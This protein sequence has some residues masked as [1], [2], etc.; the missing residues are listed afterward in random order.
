[1]D[2]LFYGE[3]EKQFYFMPYAQS[4]DLDCKCNS[5][6]TF[7]MD[8][9]A[10]EIIAASPDELI[11]DADCIVD[12]G[13]CAAKIADIKDAIGC[14]VIIIAAGYD[15]QSTLLKKFIVAGI[16][17]FVTA[18]ILGQARREY[19]AIHEGHSTLTDEDVYKVRGEALAKT[20]NSGTAFD[21]Q[22]EKKLMTIGVCGCIERIGTTT[23]ALQLAKHLSFTGRKVAYLERNKSGFISATKAAYKCEE[24]EALGKISFDDIDMFYDLSLIKKILSEGYDCLIYDYGI[25]TNENIVS[26]LEQDE[27]FICCGLKN[28]ELSGT[29]EVLRRF[30]HSEGSINYCFNFIHPSLY[31]QTLAMMGKKSSKTMF[32]GYTPEMLI[33][34]SDNHKQFEKIL[35]DNPQDIL[36]ERKKFKWNLKKKR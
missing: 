18:P 20:I 25:S 36:T 1:M 7:N 29:Y 9:A 21:E 34:E 28:K 15:M 8:T 32:L 2:I 13:D 26:L 12:D 3:K 17:D 16:K 10:G 4:K 14:K 30:L 22:Q 6:V 23:L 35:A 33:L 31:D 5:I 19:A 27:I 24:D 11:I